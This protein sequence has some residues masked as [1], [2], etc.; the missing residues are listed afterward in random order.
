MNPVF[1]PG[2]F[3]IFHLY[4]KNHTMMK[5]PVLFLAMAGG[6]CFLLLS[7]N[8]KPQTAS[9]FPEGVEKV[10]KTSCYDCHSGDARNMKAKAVLNFDKWEDYSATKK[11][12]RMGDI[13]D[14]IEKDKMPPKKYLDSSPD[15]ALT[16]AQ[17]ELLCNWSKEES[18]R[19]MESV[20]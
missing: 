14:F 6:I 17:K 12:S 20:Q 9:V 11:I 13:C 4:N 7:F 8:T 10:L 16:D 2:K 3:T 5:K 19:L 15:H 1:F 18:A